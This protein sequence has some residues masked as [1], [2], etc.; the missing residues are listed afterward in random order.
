[1]HTFYNVFSIPV[2][3]KGNREIAAVFHGKLYCKIARDSWAEIHNLESG[4]FTMDSQSG[5]TIL[6]FKILEFV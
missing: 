5:F 4:S 1:M 3:N 6:N 2:T